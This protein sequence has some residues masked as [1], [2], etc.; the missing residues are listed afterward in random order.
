MVGKETQTRYTPVFCFT[1]S[2]FASP[3]CWDTTKV[4]LEDTFLY[5]SLCS[6]RVYLLHLSGVLW[7]FEPKLLR[8][9]QKA[10]QKLQPFPGPI[11]FLSCLLFTKIPV[12]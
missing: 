12:L 10:P 5:V 11:A 7:P 8:R 2:C 4:S 3:N 6:R 1:I 9:A